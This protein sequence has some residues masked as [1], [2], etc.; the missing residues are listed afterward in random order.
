MKEIFGED[1]CYRI[2]GAAF[3][4]VCF[5][6]AYENFLSR[7]EILEQRIKQF[8]P[9]S[10]VSQKVWEQH[11]ISLERLQQQI[12]EKLAVAVNKKQNQDYNINDNDDTG[13]YERSAKIDSKW[14][15]LY[16]SSAKGKGADK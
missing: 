14:K 13:A 3:L 8:Y 7:Y 9:K 5:D 16:F 1:S 10:I 6:I 12:E 15:F 4:A 2:S 11:T